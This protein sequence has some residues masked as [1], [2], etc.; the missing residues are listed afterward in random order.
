MVTYGV[1]R[2][3]SGR[4]VYLEKWSQEQ[5]IMVFKPKTHLERMKDYREVLLADLERVE[6]HIKELEDEEKE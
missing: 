6:H 1:S 5:K 2:M 4:D 3:S